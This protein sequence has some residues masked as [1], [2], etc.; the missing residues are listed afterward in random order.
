MIKLNNKFRNVVL[1]LK[2][3]IILLIPS[4][5]FSYVGHDPLREATNNIRNVA[6]VNEDIGFEFENNPLNLGKEVTEVVGRDSAY[7]WVT[8]NRSAAENG[9][10]SGQYEAI[11][12]L[13]SN[14]TENVLS[15]TEDQPTEANVT[16]KIQHNV[17]AQRAEKV[18]KELESVKN[19]INTNMST[20]Y[21]NYVSQSVDDIREKFDAVLEKEVAF[22]NAMYEFYSPTSASL[23]G[24]IGNQKQLLEGILST[25]GT[26]Y[27]T[28]ADSLG[29]TPNDKSA[30]DQFY[31]IYKLLKN[32]N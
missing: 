22:Q 30:I 15:F 4:L 12:Y 16:Y 3:A 13:P 11:V 28:T 20:I 32:I 18:L 17:N 8:V 5:F 21:W 29:S 23:T 9:L 10:S 24:D 19:K 27:Q 7:Q 2:L 26:V 6:I 14:F 31:Q 25:A 1:I